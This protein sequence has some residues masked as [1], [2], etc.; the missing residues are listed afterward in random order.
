MTEVVPRRNVP[1]EYEDLVGNACFR[2]I[3]QVTCSIFPRMT[4][5]FPT[6][7][8]KSGILKQPLYSRSD[9][10]DADSSYDLPYWYRNEQQCT[11]M[12]GTM[13]PQ[14]QFTSDDTISDRDRVDILLDSC[15]SRNQI[16]EVSAV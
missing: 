15:K 11:T 16:V 13:P 2:Q 1:N 10:S 8:A 5:Q 3:S 4:V 12:R 9:T 7:S 6:D 14:R